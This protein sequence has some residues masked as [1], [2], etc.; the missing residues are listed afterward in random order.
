L[1]WPVAAF[2]FDKVA[3]I[4]VELICVPAM[5]AR[6]AENDSFTTDLPLTFAMFT[7]EKLD[8]LRARMGR[9]ARAAFRTTTVTRATASPPFGFVVWTYVSIS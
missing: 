2:V 3:V 7:D 8:A 9:V 6:G 1:I 5:S 4:E